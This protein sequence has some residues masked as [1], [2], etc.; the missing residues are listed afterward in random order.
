MSLSPTELTAAWSHLAPRWEG[1]DLTLALGRL[2]AGFVAGL[3]AAAGHEAWSESERLH[4]ARPDGAALEALAQALAPDLIC[5]DVDGCLIHT[6]AS[7]DG[8]VKTLVSRYTGRWPEDDE[9]LAIRR[10]GGY[11][12]DNLLA[13][14]LIRRAGVER[15]LELIFPE[16]RDLYFGTADTPGLYLRETPLIRPELLRRLRERGPIALV[17]GRNRDEL[18]LAF[19]LLDLP[20]DL[21]AWTIDDVAA[22]KPDPE[23]ILAAKSR[24][25]ARAAWMVGDNVDDILA[26]RN[27]GAVAIGVGRYREALTQAGATIVLDDINQLE[28][29]L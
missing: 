1:S 13:F 15:P 18:R 28:E 4:L 19:E 2:R 17:T 3:L 7:F 22:G 11:N 16:F 10:L 8:V 6:A 23:G 14:E 26:A 20:A 29:L 24:F 27:A 21:P 9:L 5:L 12:D 25:G